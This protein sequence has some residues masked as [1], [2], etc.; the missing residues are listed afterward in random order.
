MPLNTRTNKSI[1]LTA[2]QTSA[3]VITLAAA[4]CFTP[5]Q[6]QASFLGNIVSVTNEFNGSIANGPT[7][8]EIIEGPFLSF[9]GIPPILLPELFAFGEWDIYFESRSILFSY[10]LDTNARP[11]LANDLY[12]ITGLDWGDPTTQLVDIALT[13]IPPV[14]PIEQD[15]PILMD[16]VSVLFSDQGDSLTF[17]NRYNGPNSGYYGNGAGVLIEFISAAIPGPSPLALLALS[18]PLLLLNRSYVRP[19][20]NPADLPIYLS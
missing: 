8:V 1:P 20:R 9:P 18:L 15:R 10:A 7:A 5:P 2:S 17:I 14:A 12:T 16:D 6:A 19:L 4:L 13:L 11:L 3:I